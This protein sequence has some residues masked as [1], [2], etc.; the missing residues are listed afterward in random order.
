MKLFDKYIG[1]AKE[2]NP[3]RL[4]DSFRGPVVPAAVIKHLEGK[5]VEGIKKAGSYK[6]KTGDISIPTSTLHKFTGTYNGKTIHI[7]V[8]GNPEIPFFQVGYNPYDVDA[9]AI[10]KRSIKHE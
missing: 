7:A 10:D 9:R 8:S 1:K 4:M 5:G 2:V 6:H 3:G